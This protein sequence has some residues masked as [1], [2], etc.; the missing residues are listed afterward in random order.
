MSKLTH[1]I[2][3]GL[4]LSLLLVATLPA[5]A[6]LMRPPLRLD[7]LRAR[8][9][10]LQKQT[11][12]KPQEAQEFFIKKRAPIGTKQIPVDRYFT[13]LAHMRD[14]PQHSTLDRALIASRA[15]AEAHG[16][17]ESFLRD[18]A[19][20]WTP[21]GPG[22]IGGRTRALV[23]DPT[24][25]ATIYAAAVD[26]GVWKTT[27]A[28]ASWAPTSDLLS[29][30]AVNS[31]AM[32][33]NNPQVLF[34]GTGEG[35]FNID[36]AVGGGIFT[37]TDGAATW[38]Q[39]PNTN[40]FTFVN[41][42]EISKTTGNVY[43][44]TGGGVWRLDR[45]AGTL[46]KIFFA[47]AKQFGGCL[48]LRLRNDGA[49][50]VI[51]AACG[52]LSQATVYQNKSAQAGG[53]FVPVLSKL[54]MGRTSLAI[55]KSNPQVIY[56]MAARNDNGP[57][58][59]YNQGLYGVFRSTQGGDAGTWTTQLLDSDRTRL[60]T[61]LLSNPV[62]ANLATCGFGS[63]NLFFNQGWYD[64]VIQ[65]DPV[66]PDRVWAGGVDLWRSDDGGK[67]FGL[68]SYW[69]VEGQAASY[70]HADHH[71]IT[72]DPG[73][74]GVHNKTMYN[75]S[76]GGIFVTHDATA[77]VA[78]GRFAPCD[79]TNTAMTWTALN[80]GYAATQFYNGAVFPGGT[81]YFGGSQD[82]GTSFGAD[83]LGPNHWIKIFGGD[84]GFV[85]VNP[86]DPNLFYLENTG[87]SIA[88]TPDGGQHYFDGTHG[89]LD[90]GDFLFITPFTM[91][92]SK[93]NIL[94]T[95][96][97]FIWRTTDG[98]KNW[99]RASRLI[100]GPV[101]SAVTAIGVSP[102]NSDHVI[103]GTDVGFIMFESKA[104][105]A[106]GKTFW[107]SSFPQNAYV[108]WVTVDPNHENV[109]YATSSTF[110]TVHVIKSV[111][112]GAHW[113]IA[114][115]EGGSAALPDIPANCILVDPADSNRL[116]AG[117]DLGVF[118]SGDGGKTWAVELTGFPNT[119][120]ENLVLQK[121]GSVRTLFAFTH[122]RGVWKANI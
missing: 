3:R 94:W 35:Y 68:A 10:E 80:H 119:R 58:A 59:E 31:L 27:D 49:N 52:T 88:Y 67:N 78:R 7:V 90:F 89:I 114:D 83:S 79:P 26:G 109:I 47:S 116:Y 25:P 30:I 108:S 48:D 110:G 93:P 104:T 9:A 53:A 92:Q 98:A 122:G 64:N 76:D 32:D 95:G 23:I 102:N 70:A 54:G 5:G 39:L 66:N 91:D 112:G 61:R 100:A 71:V 60:N 4:C 105:S 24:A 42:I 12:D 97:S 36:Q 21:L 56:A 75:G 107:P 50:D 2:A 34:A 103:V 113:L 118:T 74:D 6:G 106:T 15:E 86:Q 81:A 85:A 69:W 111:D 117:T 19:T 120:V 14:M 22:N 99:Q 84:G 77:A 57:R 46:T 82:N 28:G 44:A 101:G 41:H 87:L 65:V 20:A 16:M 13:A 37:T 18:A 45:K 73:Y 51:F 63:H 72:F 1:R 11:Y 17:S 38:T 121:N 8:V 40:G 29:N 43:F 115:G 33:P 62:I 55:S 96:G